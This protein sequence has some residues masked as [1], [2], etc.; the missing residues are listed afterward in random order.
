MWK[1]NSAVNIYQIL[2]IIFLVY[3]FFFSLHQDFH[4]RKAR[5]PYGFA[6]ACTTVILTGLLALLYW[7][8]G[9]FDISQ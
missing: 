6:G 3:G 9:C 7:K 5:E 2:L 8:L 4:G 1:S